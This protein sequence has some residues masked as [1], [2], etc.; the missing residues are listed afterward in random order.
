MNKVI[1]SYGTDIESINDANGYLDQMFT[2]LINEYNFPVDKATIF[3]IFDRD[4][5]SNTKTDVIEGLIYQLS[6]SR[7]NELYAK[8]GLL[9]LSYPS[10]ESFITS[11]FKEN[12]INLEFE[13]GKEVKTYL[14]ENQWSIQKINE[15]TLRLASKEMINSLSVIG[16]E[17]YD[18]DDFGKFN[19]LLF[20]YQEK[21]YMD[22]KKYRMLSLLCMAFIDLGLIEVEE[23]E[24]LE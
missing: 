17:D 23:L 4:V 16:I 3:Y 7:E 8:A 5:K 21:Y 1:N 19:R 24:K 13:L 14:H 12:S 18:L 9:L 15:G 11:N 22:N 10:I 6:N 2:R 20:E